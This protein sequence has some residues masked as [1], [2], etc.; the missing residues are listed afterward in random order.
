MRE[1]SAYDLLVVHSFRVAVNV[2]VP[3]RTN[4]DNVFWW[5]KTSTVSISYSPGDGWWVISDS[6]YEFDDQEADTPHE[7]EEAAR[8]MRQKLHQRGYETKVNWPESWPSDDE[9]LLA[10]M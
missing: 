10:E 2:E 4:G 7:V 3:L 1:C 9:E 5:V 6:S 8:N